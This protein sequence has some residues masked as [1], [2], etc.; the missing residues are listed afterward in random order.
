[1][2][3]RTPAPHSG[4][5]TTWTTYFDSEK[6]GDEYGYEEKDFGD[7]DEDDFHHDG[8]WYDITFLKCDDSANEIEFEVDKCLKP[9]V[10]SLKVVQEFNIRY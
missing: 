10:A 1:M 3:T 4:D 8:R 6:E 2:P 9:S 5:I 7:I